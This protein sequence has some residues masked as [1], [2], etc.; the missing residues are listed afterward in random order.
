MAAEIVQ[1]RLSAIMKLDMAGFSR[2]M[3]RNEEDTH[4]RVQALF[5][6]VV[7]PAVEDARGRIVKLLGDGALVEFPAVSDAI[8]CALSIQDIVEAAATAVEEDRRIRLRIGINLGDVIVDGEDIYGDGVNIAA[9]IESIAE[10]GTVYVSEAAMQIADRARFRFIDLGI[11]DLKNIG[12]PIRTFRALAADAPEALAM[13]A[14]STRVPGFGDRPAIAVLPLQNL[15]ADPEREYLADGLT[16]DIITELSSF[17]IFPVIARNSVFA[18]KGRHADLRVVGSQ[19]GARYVLDGS[20]RPAGPLLRITTQLNDVET[21]QTL[22]AGRYDRDGAQV[23]AL[24]DDIVQEIVGTLEPELLRHERERAV[25]VSSNNPTAYDLYQRGMWHHYRYNPADSLQARAFFRNAL[26]LDEDFGHAAAALAV[27]LCQAV[28][29]NFEPAENAAMLE[30]AERQ[31]RHALRCDP[32][33]PS[34]HFAMGVVRSHIHQLDAA[35][36]ALN[37]AGR[38]N[39]SFA[40]AH[41]F[42]G[43]VLNYLNRPAEAIASIELA[44]RLSPHDPRRFLWLPALASSHYLSGRYQEAL[45]VTREAQRQNPDYLVPSRYEVACLG[46]LGRD[47]DARRAIARLR[48]LDPDLSAC[49]RVLRHYFVPEAAAHIIAGLRKAGFE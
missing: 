19:L 44:L 43:F 1:R 5:Q 7:A 24:Q 27:T 31:A 42:R 38:L 8:G 40:A 26:A 2:L 15:S 22:F 6:G 13:P 33:D 14:L 10:P 49:A 18:Y 48:H 3:A 23:I 39:P 37:E 20:L 16:D 21:G 28:I 32:R 9:R 45:E 12:R 29:S 25:S 34:A 47:V 30:E 46:Q 36:A 35:L 11:R 17:R 41:A 4:R